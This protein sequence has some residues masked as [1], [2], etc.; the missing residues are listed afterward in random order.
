MLMLAQK[1]QILA[2]RARQQHYASAAA[3]MLIIEAAPML[4]IEAAPML[5]IERSS[6]V[7]N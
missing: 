7:D 3:P 5:I 2:N 6:N 4:I 1:L